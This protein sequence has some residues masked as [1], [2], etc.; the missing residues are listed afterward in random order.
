MDHLPSLSLYQSIRMI[1]HVMHEVKLREEEYEFVKDMSLHTEGLLPSVQLARRERRLLWH[2]EMIYLSSQQRSS[3]KRSS[4][5]RRPAILSPPSSSRSGSHHTP[6]IILSPCPDTPIMDDRK[7]WSS[8]TV[9]NKD[10]AL[11]VSVFTDALLLTEAASEDPRSS[12]KLFADVG[13][14]RILATSSEHSAGGFSFQ[15]KFESFLT[16]ASPTKLD[17]LKAQ[18]LCH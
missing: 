5:G 16:L 13:I 9:G 14:S 17:P 1:V 12:Y 18:T 2:G 3:N 15:P 11:Y 6:A 10:I 7:R 4:Q 8:K